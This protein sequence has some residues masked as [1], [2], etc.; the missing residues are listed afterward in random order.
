[1]IS[2]SRKGR[3]GT[4]ERGR[5]YSLEGR[6]VGKEVWCEIDVGAWLLGTVEVRGMA[7]YARQ[8]GGRTVVILM[9]RVEFL[10]KGNRV[11]FAGEW[12]SRD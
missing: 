10:K 12:G 4:S 5:P 11:K 2:G 7:P 8:A 9:E 3:G 6:V 1:V